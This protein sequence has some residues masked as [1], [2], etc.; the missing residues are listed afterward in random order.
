MIGKETKQA[1]SHILLLLKIHTLFR[2]RQRFRTG[3]ANLVRF[4]K[5]QN[6]VGK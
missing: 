1:T 4:L 5:C 6:Y 2:N 3:I